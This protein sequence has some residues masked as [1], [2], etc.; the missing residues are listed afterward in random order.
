MFKYT[1]NHNALIK[2]KKKEEDITF[3][4]RLG[5][6]HILAWTRVLLNDRFKVLG[7]AFLLPLLT[8]LDIDPGP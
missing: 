6:I 5:R 1:N 7:A 8:Y 2:L 3:F 4:K